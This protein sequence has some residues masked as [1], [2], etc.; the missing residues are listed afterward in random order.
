[1]HEHAADYPWIGDVNSHVLQPIAQI[2]LRLI[3]MVVVPLVFS[4]LV[5]GV[6]ELGRGRGFGKIAGRTLLFTIIASALSVVIGVTLVNVIRPGDDV[7]VN[8]SVLQ[9]QS[10]T[11]GKLQESVRGAKTLSETIVDLFPK[12]PL[13]T[14][15]RALTG[16]MLP[17]MMFALI[18]GVAL[19]L[20]MRERA[21]EPTLVRL[22]EQVFAVSM[23]IIEFAM[24]LAPVA[25]F[26]LIFN[27]VFNSGLDILKSLG[28][29]VAAVVAGL[30]IQLLVVY[31]ALLKYLAR[32]SPVE[33]FRGCRDVLLYAL[34]TSSSNATLPV[35]LEAADK[36]LGLPPDVSRFVLT[37]GATANQNGTALFEGVV[38]L[39]LAQV[40]DVPLT[41]AQQVQVALL[42]IVAGIG[43]AGVPGGSLPLIMILLQ[44]F[45][46]PPEGIGLILGVDRFL[47]PCRTAINVSGDLVIT[48][49]VSGPANR[50]A[51]AAPD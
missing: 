35:S 43:T 38:I 1:M 49:L 13:D 47:D 19:M 22:L 15:M 46:I 12:N 2:F 24:L 50:R 16:E 18:F 34:S 44:H 48:A 37:V 26:A 3:F 30:L 33:F 39:F 41:L 6:Y 45:N 36:K 21:E 5:L 42:A 51:L 23:K 17:F 14:A 8:E 31:S 20:V 7:A 27:T 25:V 28:L 11:I 40:Y 9:Q 4:A 29:F 32:R 10:A